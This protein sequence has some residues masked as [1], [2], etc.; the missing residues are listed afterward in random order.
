MKNVGNVDR[1]IRILLIGFIFYAYYVGWTVGWV[2]ALISIAVVVFLFTTA[3]RA[4]CPLY[5]QIG[6]STRQEEKT[7]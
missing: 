7:F 1:V 4:Q 3:G 5:Q 6:I 2:V